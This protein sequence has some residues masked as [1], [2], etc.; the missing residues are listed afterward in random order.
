MSRAAAADW[1]ALRRSGAMT[2]EAAA[3]LEAWLAD[4]AN[5]A[6]FADVEATWA[7]ADAARDDPAMLA[8]PVLRHR[9]SLPSSWR[10]VMARSLKLTM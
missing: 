5:R 8:R 9:R 6:A 2:D 7:L 10:T 4:P 3:E 1:F